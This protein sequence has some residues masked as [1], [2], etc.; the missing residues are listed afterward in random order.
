MSSEATL[1]KIRF[2]NFWPGFD[3]CWANLFYRILQGVVDR[4][5]NIVS[6][7]PLDALSFPPLPKYKHEYWFSFS[8]ESYSLPCHHWDL[9]MI[10]EK[11][12]IPTRILSVPLF[13]AYAYL[14]NHW[15]KLATPRELKKKT[16]FCS[17]VVSNP[18]GRERNHYYNLLSS[19]QRVDSWGK[20]LNNM[21][22][23]LSDGPWDNRFSEYKFM[24]CFENTIKPYY[25]TE[26][27][28]HAYLA[29]TI[30][31]YAGASIAQSWLNPKAFI[32]ISD[33]TTHGQE[34]TIRQI[35]RLSE[36]RDAYAEI[37]REPLLRQPQVPTMM[38]IP[39]WRER[40]SEI[41][42]S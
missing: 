5:T 36:D 32:Q 35:R 20:Y 12:D 7:F 37:F 8:G 28:L 27:L 40:I 18:N 30:P 3:R 21:N 2:I 38:S 13:S 26:K 33:F 1:E 17:M 39:Y 9:N 14:G 41:L 19:Y 23:L 29:G 11:E 4:P 16:S 10:M 24:L 31:I 25:L 6:V 15:E 42:G 22:S 34:E